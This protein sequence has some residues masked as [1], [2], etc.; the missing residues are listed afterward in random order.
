MVGIDRRRAAAVAGCVGLVW[1]ATLLVPAEAAGRETRT[2][3]GGRFELTVGFLNEPAYE[4]E[5]NGLYVRVYE[6]PMPAAES[7]DGVAAQATP[8]AATPVGEATPPG[9]PTPV[10]GSELTAEIAYG[11]DVRPLKLEP[12]SQ[13][14]VYQAAFVPTQPGNY[15]FRI[16]GTLDGEEIAE[17]FR[18]SP[19]GIPPVVGVAG[20]QFP[21]EIPVGQ[22]LLDALDEREAEAERA[23][24][25]GA[26]GIALGVVG[27]LAGGI[28]VVLSRRPPPGGMP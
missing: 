15:I 7:A 13:P 22:G 23:R 17:E 24:T 19:L 20:L 12:G 28:A 9:S 10:P 14:G 1:L 11:P 8:S 3:V 4:G 16:K 6:V 26:V 2:V 25:L 18:T 21:Q 27:L 5:P